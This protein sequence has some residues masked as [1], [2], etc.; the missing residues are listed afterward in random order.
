MMIS[1]VVGFLDIS[2][3]R[4]LYSLV[5]VMSRKLILFSFSSSRVNFIVGFRLLNLS[6]MSCMLILYI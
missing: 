3:E 6:R 4:L 2:N 1:V 5:I